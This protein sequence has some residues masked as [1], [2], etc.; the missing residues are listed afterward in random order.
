MHHNANMRLKSSLVAWPLLFLP[1]LATPA[2]TAVSVS[3]QVGGF[4]IS[5]A[6]YFGL[7]EREVILLRERRIPDNEIPVVL[8]I[9]QQA[10][11]A[12]AA[13]MDFRQRGT[14][15]W[16]ISVHFG[17][18]PDLYYVPVVGAPGPPY[19]K[20]YGYYKKPRDQWRTI[21][22]DDAD[23]VNLVNLRFLSGHHKVP[24]ERV[25]DLRSK[26][27]GFVSIHADLGTGRP[28]RRADNV[29]KGAGNGKGK[30]HKK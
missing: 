8:F 16:D 18:G 28:Y 6:N 23:I 12:P 20:A 1:A 10:R 27:K 30:G 24:P 2:E 17:I 5:V 14:S 11:V 9:A 15:W 29:W 26:N 21:V 25:I 7:P 22:L 3:G 13:V 4:H 19:G